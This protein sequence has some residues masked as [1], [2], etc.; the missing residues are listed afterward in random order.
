MVR[1]TRL[2]FDQSPPKFA[3]P[4]LAPHQVR[5]AESASAPRTASPARI[6]NL[7]AATGCGLRRSPVRIPLRTPN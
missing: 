1:I 6:P 3:R 2:K 7:Q 5:C 4:L